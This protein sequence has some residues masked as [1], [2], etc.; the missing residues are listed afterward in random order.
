MLES[1]T[2]IA[3]PEEDLLPWD[4]CTARTRHEADRQWEARRARQEGIRSR[5]QSEHPSSRL[6]RSSAMRPAW[7]A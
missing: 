5:Y 6:I 2:L 3:T 1:T 4:A 7:A